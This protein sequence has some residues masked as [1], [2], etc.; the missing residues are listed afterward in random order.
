MSP[1]HIGMKSHFWFSDIKADHAPYL[2]LVWINHIIVVSHNL[3]FI[4]L[5]WTSFITCSPDI[6]FVERPILV[7]QGSFYTVQLKPEQVFPE[8]FNGPN[9]VAHKYKGTSGNYLKGFLKSSVLGPA[10]KGSNSVHLGEATRHIY[11]YLILNY[12]NEINISKAE[13]Q[14]HLPYFKCS[15]ATCGWLVATMLNNTDL[16]PFV[17]TEI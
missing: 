4:S 6:L 12:L 13:S 5:S 11:D 16:E 14:F 17:M 7:D 3:Y 1:T 2:D 10:H 9:S 15:I 8:I